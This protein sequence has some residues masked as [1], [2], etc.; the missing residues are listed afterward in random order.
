MKKKVLL[1]GWDAADWN[2]INPLLQQGRLPTLAGLINR[3]VKGNMSTMNPP[4]SPM[5]WTSVATGKTPDKHGV[6][7]FIEIETEQQIVR[8]VTVTQRK[9]RAI[10]NILH[11]KGLKS[12]LIGWWP[13]HPA[14]PINGVVVSDLFPKPIG[15]YEEKWPLPKGCIHPQS[16]TTEL[17][18]LRMHPQ[19]LTGAHILP[20]I[21][22]AEKIE[23]RDEKSL[24]ILTKIVAHNTSVHA[25]H[26]WLME[27]S[28]WNFT[29]V[30]Y[31]M[32]DHFCHAFMK[33]HPPKLP[34]ISQSN[35]DIFKHAVEGAYIYQ[36]MMLERSLQL[37][38]DDTL[39]V[40]M[41]DH[42]Y[43]SG[44]N[45]MLTQPDIH[46]SPAL[47]HREFGMFVM[48][49][50]GIKRNE[51]VYG[52]SLLDITPTL[53]H[54]LELPVGEDMDGRILQDVFENVSQPKM[55]PS[56]DTVQG[57][58]GEHQSSQKGDAFSEQAAM[59]QL[60]ELGYIDR[61]DVDIEKAI[62]ETK[63]D[64]RF[65]LARVH[66]GKREYEKC[67]KILRELI[68]EEGKI[69]PY[70]VDL[71][72][73]CLIKE[74]YTEARKH[75]EMLRQE[76]P[77]AA[78]KTL[79]TEA[80]IL[81]GEGHVKRAREILD[82][83][84]KKK[85]LTGV[86]A[87]E[88]GKIYM[89]LEDFEQALTHFKKAV[90]FQPDHAKYQ[91]GTAVA[92]LKLKQPEMALEHAL[93]SV[94]LVR[95]FPDAHYTVGQALEM[96]GDTDGAE[97]AYRTAERLQPKMNRAKLAAE[98]LSVRRNEIEQITTVSSDFP[99]VIIVSGLPRSGTSMMMQMLTAG[100]LTP[101]T[102]N[103]RK[104]DENNP[105]GYFEYEKTKSLHKNNDWLDEAEGKVLKVVAPL[106]KHLPANYRYKVIFMT[107]DLDEVLASQ[108][109]MLRRSGAQ[110]QEGV[111]AS[112][113]RE[114]Q[115][116]DERMAAEPGFEVCKIAY[117][118]VIDSPENAAK[119]IEKFIGQ[120][121]NV[122]AMKDQVE[123]KLYRN[124]V[125]RF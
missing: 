121:M 95:Y 123:A 23:E 117:A 24:H 40:V 83:L 85:S 109:K 98:N 60:I 17:S 65:N 100:G 68:Q 12:N 122:A 75:L 104:S 101:L 105:K 72:H 125:M 53:L 35:Y 50:P 14:E 6:L 115:K 112:Y 119:V 84:S 124:R 64:L 66:L 25:A 62:K 118:D 67:E 92:Y 48:S 70:L 71:I 32:I 1:I 20:F 93:N 36:D 96:L 29:G 91:H 39:V 49:G 26:T 73:V 59:E 52:A 81:L 103:V 10:W 13:S 94:E 102:D 97:N 47:E 4:Y 58:F 42:G 57:D 89:N 44:N 90:A 41:S 27:N 11:H 56:W 86:I 111:R 33:F 82:E 34:A 76:D 74:D 7:G 54:Y 88:L 77:K 87:Y 79:L 107:R 28:E 110:P 16:L 45:R 31:D 120:K 69:T 108:D 5:L 113:Q 106:L 37:A 116:L 38:G 99:E 46:A 19:E 15:K 63:K 18:D 22:K 80:K 55:I 3:G 21:P 61:P 43:V 2:I 114:L 78:S 51:T 9:T 30:Y 8:P